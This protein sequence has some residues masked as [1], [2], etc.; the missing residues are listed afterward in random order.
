MTVMH[1]IAALVIVTLT[2]LRR[3]HWNHPK[4]V[5]TAASS[6][7]NANNHARSRNVKHLSAMKAGS[8]TMPV[9]CRQPSFPLLLLLLIMTMKNMM[10]MH[11][12]HWL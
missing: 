3:V 12:L 5:T 2:V 1:L 11:K 7:S 9:P 4:Q 8:V 10:V 6:I